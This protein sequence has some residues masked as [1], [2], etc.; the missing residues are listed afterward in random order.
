[1][2]FFVTVIDLIFKILWKIGLNISC[3]RLILDRNMDEIS[4]HIYSH[5]GHIPFLR[6]NCERGT[7]GF[8]CYYLYKRSDEFCIR[9]FIAFINVMKI[10][11][12]K[13]LHFCKVACALL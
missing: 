7:T 11:F 9:K 4:L 3:N 2:K 12:Y 13:A 5:R 8:Q 1:M 6:D 10:H